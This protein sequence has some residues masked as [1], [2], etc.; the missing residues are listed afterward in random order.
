[1]NENKEFSKNSVIKLARKSGIKCIS[2]CA[3]NKIKNITEKQ[4]KELTDKL[5]FFFSSKFKTSKTMDKETVKFF[6][7][8]EG[9]KYTV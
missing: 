2:D 1:M 7:E 4:I 9:I 3:I 6:L 5:S 8:S